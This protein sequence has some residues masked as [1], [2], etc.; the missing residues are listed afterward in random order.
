MVEASELPFRVLCRRHGCNGAY[1]PM[2][3]SRLFA[4]KAAQQ[5]NEPS[6][7][8]PHPHPSPLTLTL[9]LNLTP[10]LTLTLTLT[11]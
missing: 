1:S 11:Y 8:T 6:P 7:L 5:G 2:L 4:A 9:T 10:T 3:H